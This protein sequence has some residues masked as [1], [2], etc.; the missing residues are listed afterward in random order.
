MRNFSGIS[1]L[2]LVLVVQLVPAQISPRAG[3]GPPKGMMFQEVLAKS[4]CHPMEQL[5]DVEQEL[6]GEVGYIY[7]P[8]CVPLKRCAGCC[9]DDNLECHPVLEHNIT[10]QMLKIAPM[11]SSTN[12]QLTFVEHQSCECRLRQTLLKNKSSESIKNKPRGR[13]HKKTANGCG[14]CQFP[15]NKINIP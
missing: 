3:D 9:G 8:A 14:K 4:M 13:K 1:H 7:V 2:L 6:P 10:V 5:V 11:T 15:Q 12:V